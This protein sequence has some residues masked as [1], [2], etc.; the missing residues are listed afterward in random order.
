MSGNANGELT[1]QR[2]QI[3]RDREEL[4]RTVQAL[5]EK[6]D[7]QARAKDAFTAAKVKVHTIARRY[8]RT[9]ALLAATSLTS[10]ATALVALTV[11]WR[12]R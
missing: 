8:G 5:A 2:Q 7:V 6:V 12:R 10:S 4:G 3:A 9:D 1:R 11:W